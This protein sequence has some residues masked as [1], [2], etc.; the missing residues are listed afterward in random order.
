MMDA[1]SPGRMR[2]LQASATARGIFTILAVDHR[3]ALRAM[4]QPNAP[5]AVSAAQLTEVKLAIVRHLAPGASAVLL[6]PVYSAAQAIVSGSLP[7]HVGLLCALEEQGYLGDALNR[8]TTL[9]SG[10]SVAKAKRLGAT[11]V[12]ILLFY[13]P[14]AGLAAEMQEQL[15]RA[16]LADCQRYDLPLFLEPIA[17]SP[18]PKAKKGTE[19]FARQ[20]RRIVVESA[21]RLSALQPDVLKVEFPIDVRYESDKAVWREACAELNEAASVP[22]ALLSADEPFETFK[23]QLRIA[24]EAGASGFLA[25]RSVWREAAT[26]VGEAREAF[27]AV[28][29]RHRFGELVEIAQA[30]GKPWTESGTLPQANEAWYQGY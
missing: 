7:G 10:W 11:G 12:K 25:G 4:V 26:L 27:L 17:Y 1:L 18:D 20:R 22:W 13:H 5:E 14:E 23:H 28:T 21:R 8:Q 29:A 15:V 9:L 30:F 6:D 2:S 24:C 16:A 3:D 19:G